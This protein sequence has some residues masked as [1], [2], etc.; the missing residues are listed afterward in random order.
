[1]EP[2]A[3]HRIVSNF[4]DHGVGCVSS[5]DEV[6][7]EQNNRGGEGSYVNFEMWLRRL[8]AQ[9]GTMVSVSGSFFAARR[10][11]CDVWHP[12]Q[13]SDFFVPLHTAARSMRVVVDPGC[14]GRYGITQQ[15]DAE[16]QRK[17]RTV[18]H[19]LVVF[20]TH[21]KLLNP[22]HYPLFGWQLVSHK[23]CRWLVPF[24]LLALWISNW[25]LWSH[26]AFYQ[27]CFILQTILYTFGGIAMLSQ[28]TLRLK[29]FKL[30]GF[31]MLGNLAT[32]AAWAHFCAGEEFVFWQPTQ[33]D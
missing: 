14:R 18:V 16:F 8:E 28:R 30:A 15:V 2:G 5:E 20:F 26:G 24:A 10:E 19:G 12:Q 3:L 31:F 21:L 4:A 32:I 33:R 23:L 27:L 1:L 9:V 29:P 25:F 11:L 13:S 17:V 22:F 6:P 7:S